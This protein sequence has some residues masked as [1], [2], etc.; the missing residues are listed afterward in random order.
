MNSHNSPR[1][2]SACFK[3]FSCRGNSVENGSRDLCQKFPYTEFCTHG[4]QWHHVVCSFY[5][6]AY[7][8]IYCKY[9]P[10][11]RFVPL[12]CLVIPTSIQSLHRLDSH[13][14]I[15]QW[16]L[17]K[18]EAMVMIKGSVGRNWGKYDLNLFQHSKTVRHVHRNHWTC[19]TQHR[20]SAPSHDPNAAVPLA[21]HDGSTPRAKCATSHELSSQELVALHG[22]AH[23]TVHTHA[24]ACEM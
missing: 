23:L 18:M 16:R 22:F 7:H 12:P 19:Q 4:P 3:V 14:A 21:Q 9:M 15:R 17:M 8:S 6:I 24:Q 13:G 11:R 1:C 5:N 20:T 10:L 2:T